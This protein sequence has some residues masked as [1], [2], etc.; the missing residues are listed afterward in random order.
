ME[1]FVLVNSFV[2][3]WICHA[4]RCLKTILD[5]TKPFTEYPLLPVQMKSRRFPAF[6]KPPEV[7]FLARPGRL[8]QVCVRA[9]QPLFWIRGGTTR[10]SC[11]QSCG[12]DL[13]DHRE[14]SSRPRSR[15]RIS[16][17]DWLHAPWLPTVSSLSGNC[18]E[19]PL[20][21]ALNSLLCSSP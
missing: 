13:H 6:E 11:V 12:K 10:S 17:E 5:L 16:G 21:K 8:Y 1:E 4:L 7:F 18:P 20:C 19:E 3:A 2:C 15:W 14:G 9:S